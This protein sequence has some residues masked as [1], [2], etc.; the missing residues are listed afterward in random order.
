[1]IENQLA[2][3][4][5]NI[6]QRASPAPGKP[7]AVDFSLQQK[8]TGTVITSKRSPKHVTKVPEPS[9]RYARSQARLSNLRPTPFLKK[10]GAEIGKAAGTYPILDVACGTGRNGIF[11]SQLGRTVI[12]IDKD[13]SRLPPDGEELLTLR[14]TK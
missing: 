6:L 8:C 12:C 10:F 11:L 7:N 9:Q 4:R 13:L 3:G 14:L 1:I 2:I 5:T